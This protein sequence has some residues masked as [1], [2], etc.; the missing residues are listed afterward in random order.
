MNTPPPSVPYPGPGY[1]VSGYNTDG[2]PIYTHRADTNDA[3]SGGGLGWRDSGYPHGKDP[4]FVDNRVPAIHDNFAIMSL[5][6]S[7]VWLAGAGGILGIVFGC[8]SHAEARKTNRKPSALAS[9]GIGLSI[10]GFIGTIILIVAVVHASH[11]TGIPGLV[12]GV[13]CDNIPIPY[14]T[15][16]PC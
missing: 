16:P 7:L 12:P 4:Q 9:W 2:S 8:I 11:A 14:S 13:T 6:F 15:N 5:I 3:K 10:L 1:Y